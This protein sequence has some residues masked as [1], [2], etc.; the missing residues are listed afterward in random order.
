MN[1]DSFHERLQ[2]QEQ[3]KQV[4]LEQARAQKQAESEALITKGKVMT[5][6]QL[7]GMAKRLVD[8]EAK[9]LNRLEQVSNTHSVDCLQ[10]LNRLGKRQ[11]R[12]KL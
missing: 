7:D 4:K 11:H 8:D 1:F 2:K 3:A 5:E 9:R 10:W 6:E 12:G